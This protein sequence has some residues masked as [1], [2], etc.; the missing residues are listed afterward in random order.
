MPTKTTPQV[1]DFARDVLGRYI[2]NGLDEALRSMEK[3]ALR[4]DGSPQADARPFDIIV[5][6]G[7]TFGSAVAQHLFYQDKTHSHRI[8]VLEGG[9]FV[10]P[11]HVQN[12]PL[13]GL[14][15][16]GPT[17]IKDLRDA[18]QFTLDRPRQEVWGLPWH[19]STPFPG[20]AYAIGGR[21]LF[22]GGWSPQLLDS[23][24]PASGNVKNLWPS[25]VVDNLNTRYFR[26]ASEQIGVTETNDFIHGELHEALR[27]QLHAGLKNV[28]AA[29]PLAKLPLHLDVPK[30]TSRPQQ[31]L[32]KL[33]APLA[34]QTVTRPGFFPFNKFSAIPLL[35]KAA[36]AAQGESGNDDVKKRLMVVPNCHVK[37]LVPK[38][39]PPRGWVV[40][41]VETNLGNVPVPDNGVV[42]IALATIESTRLALQ[43][44]ED[45]P[46][47]GRSSLPIGN[48]LMAHL[49]SNLDIRVP[50]EALQALDPTV[51]ELQASALFVKGRHTHADGTVGHFHLQITAS[52][53]GT[54]GTNSEAELFKKVPDI[55]GFDTFRAADDTRVV[56]TIRGIGEM[57]PQNPNSFVRLDPEPDEFGMRRAF[58]SITPS[59]KD[60]A[61]W[62]V[63]DKAS[64]DV[65]KVFASN[66]VF[67][68]FTPKGI[69]KVQSDANLRDVL[70]Y[71]PR[72]VGG[73]RD[74]LGTT[75]HEAGTLWIGDD[76]GKSV[77][78]SNGRIHGTSNV[79]VAA[80]ALFPTIGSPNPM[81]TGVALGRRLCDH[82]APEPKPYMPP[83]ADFTALF[84]GFTTNSW[85]MA[86]SGNF[87]VVAGTL[88]SVP[89]DDLGLYWCTTPTPP[90]FILKLQWLRFRHE[91][92]SGV[93]IRF[94]H[95][96]SKRY[97][98]TAY[99]GVHFGFEAQIDELGAPDGADIHKTGA[100]YNEPSQTRSLRPARPAG[101]WND[102][103]IRVQEQSYTVFL[104]GEQV[105]SFQNPH[106]N[107]GLLGT[108]RA[109][110]F[111]GLQA[112]PGSRVAFRNI[113]IKGV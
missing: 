15:V 6:G 66:H 18:G 90:D 48:N 37:R 7:G 39:A 64:D 9:P 68:V 88:E 59:S 3:N 54:V 101:E 44:Y 5:I 75:H 27:K 35:Q 26:E 78:N 29:I 95:P 91:D 34:V 86:G 104:N 47:E 46:V 81:L 1:T 2:C 50:R 107:R 72:E 53:L 102:F 83:E 96:D 84:D 111:I 62:E 30:G 110:S 79:Y 16:P 65:A 112:Y 71:T 77:T 61:L 24:M 105:T 89:G 93:F 14:G 33:E 108:P 36:R 31:E 80:P 17:S 98:N 42:I 92:N 23:E 87:I 58:V 99:V 28:T 41:V 103:E 63:M 113:R 51:K 38:S 100:I 10:L 82:L 32:M 109:P 13:V 40:A 74:G 94:P 43:L 12:L 55:D 57:E 73:R 22:W 60:E 97:N 8:L 52:G 4:P 49:R 106:A 11:E 69:K 19:S 25:G 45:I 56:I 67:E 20:L 85:R 76:S 70:P 21:S